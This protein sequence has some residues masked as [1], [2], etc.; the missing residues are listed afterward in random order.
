NN[1]TGRTQETQLGGI[2][3]GNSNLGGRA[4]NVILNARTQEPWLSLSRY[5]KE[6]L[7]HNHIR[8]DNPM[9]KSQTNQ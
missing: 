4:A 1:A 6:Q 5:D 7:T 2:I 9:Q 8:S 3:L